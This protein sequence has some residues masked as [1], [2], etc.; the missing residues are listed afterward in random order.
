[1]GRAARFCCREILGRQLRRRFVFIFV[2]V[3]D[4]RRIFDTDRHDRRRW[5][6]RDRRQRDR[7]LMS[8]GAGN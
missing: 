7:K 3:A 2:D 1:V 8:A 6:D 4:L 5:R